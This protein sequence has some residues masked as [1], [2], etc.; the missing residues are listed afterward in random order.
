MKTFKLIFVLALVFFAGAITGVVATRAVVRH[1][2]R[3]AMTNPDRIQT[4]IER[5][6]AWRLRLDGPQRAK[7]H[8][9]LSGTH[10]QLV[11]LRQQY[12]PQF[13]SILTN[14]DSQISAI[15]TPAQEERYDQLKA[16][17]RSFL[18]GIGSHD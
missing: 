14:A 2:V 12:R 9:I 3:E 15:L 8:E 5:R 4:L 1:V 10:Q 18:P 16:E 11:D 17:N 7:L 6:L 13:V